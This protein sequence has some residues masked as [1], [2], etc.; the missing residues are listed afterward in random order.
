MHSWTAVLRLIPALTLFDNIKGEYTVFFLGFVEY[1]SCSTCQSGMTRETRNLTVAKP[2]E[3]YHKGKEA[4][5][6]NKT[7]ALGNAIPVLGVKP[8]RG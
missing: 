3:A 6:K 7:S 1:F 2:H 4:Y 5:S 8:K